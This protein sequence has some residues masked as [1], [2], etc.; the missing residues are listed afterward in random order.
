MGL[1]VVHGIIQSHG[2]AI[3]VESSLG[4]GTTFK[5]FLPLVQG[6]EAKAMALADTSPTGS[7]HILLVDDEP[8]LAK[9]LALTLEGL[10]YRVTLAAS[11]RE[12]L[13]V[14]N[15]APETFDLMVTD[16]TMPEM[17]GDLLAKEA[18]K[19][20][21]GFPVIICTGYSDILD[22]AKARAMGIRAL[23]MKPVGQT[24]L[25]ETLRRVLDEAV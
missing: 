11:P 20:R 17:T 9:M 10:G 19:I 24:K 6:E 16:Q 15:D 2:G 18:M 1:S 22:D 7:E 25:A 14:F 23:L 4:A 3:G 12:A 8:A 21:P 13:D 5:V